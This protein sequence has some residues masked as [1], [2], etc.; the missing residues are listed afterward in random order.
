MATTRSSS[1]HPPPGLRSSAFCFRYST[2]E[3]TRKSEA[4]PWRRGL[5]FSFREVELEEPKSPKVG[6]MG[7]IKKVDKMG[8]SG[9]S[10]K[11]FKLNKLFSGKGFGLD[12]SKTAGQRRMLK[13]GS[14]KV[15]GTV[16]PIDR[17]LELDPPLPV[18][19][20]R[21]VGNGAVSLWKRRGVQLEGLQLHN[22]PAPRLNGTDGLSA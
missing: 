11:F 21:E 9:G 1:N 4:S 13:N 8:A 10:H 15:T 2:R 18:K 6:C 14:E 7:Q 12:T 20:V 3:A 17:L 16:L 19:K 22:L 5:S